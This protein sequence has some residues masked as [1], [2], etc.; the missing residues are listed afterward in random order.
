[1][2]MSSQG[3]SVGGGTCQS[4]LSMMSGHQHVGQWHSQSVGDWEMAQGGSLLS[5]SSMKAD[6]R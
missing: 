6:C 2:P 5:T 4:G 1:V 3:S